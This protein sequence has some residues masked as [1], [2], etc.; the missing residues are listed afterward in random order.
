M[1]EKVV[2][3]TGKKDEVK[4]EK[5]PK[6]FPVWILNLLIFIFGIAIGAGALFLLETNGYT[7]LI[8]LCN[9]TG[10]AQ[11]DETKATDEGS[12]TE[13]ANQAQTTTFEGDYITAELPQGWTIVEYTDENGSDMIMDGMTYSGLVGLKVFNP[14][15]DE[16]FYLKAVDGIGGLAGCDEVYQFTDSAVAYLGLGNDLTGISGVTPTIVDLTAQTYSEYT[17][18]GFNIRRID[19][20]IYRDAYDSDYAGFNAGCGIDQFV[21]EL[22]TLSYERTIAGSVDSGHTYSWEIPSSAPLTDLDTLDDIL[23]SLSIN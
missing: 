15:S 6:S 20:E 11:E 1:D 8:E 21:F 16:M 2:M 9:T 7:N 14:N 10:T 12:E 23:E 19:R 22:S 17:L 4:A 13:V 5:T 3:E 18:L